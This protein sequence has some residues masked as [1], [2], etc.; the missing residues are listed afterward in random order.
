MVCSLSLNECLQVIIFPRYSPCKPMSPSDGR[1]SI[2]PGGW[3]LGPQCRVRRFWLIFHLGFWWRRQWVFRCFYRMFHAI[4]RVGRRLARIM[5]KERVWSTRSFRNSHLLA[6]HQQLQSVVEGFDMTVFF[7]FRFGWSHT[8]LL[9]FFGGVLRSSFTQV[10]T[11]FRWFSALFLCIST[12][13]SSLSTFTFHTDLSLSYT[14]ILTAIS[15]SNL[16]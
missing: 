16:S 15:H 12:P 9:R 1:G 14:T 7:H 3:S 2:P 5:D 13:K 4:D 8:S 11:V 6:I 10:W